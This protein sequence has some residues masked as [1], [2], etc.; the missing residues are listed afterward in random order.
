[1]DEAQFWKI[2]ASGGKKVLDDQ[3][4]QLAAIRKELMKLP[5]KVVQAFSRIY[6]SK[7]DEAYRWDVWGAAYVI[8][9]GCSDDGFHYF[10]GWLI[11]RGQETFEKALKEPDSLAKITDPENDWYEFEELE[12][13]PLE[14]YEK[15]TGEQMPREAD[16][17]P[18]ETQGK[19]WDFDDDKE[20]LR[21]FPKLA[22]AREIGK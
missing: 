21:R 16:S 13:L 18:D 1:M 15:L 17:M 19:Q 5:P 2:I 4:L 20:V 6:G 3:E 8:N 22:K 14:V 11:S 7:L 12:Y 10:R 9:G